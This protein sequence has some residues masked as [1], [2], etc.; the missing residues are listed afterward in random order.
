[1]RNY[2]KKRLKSYQRRNR[3]Y[4]ISFKRFNTGRRIKLGLSNR[5]TNTANFWNGVKEYNKLLYELPKHYKSIVRHFNNVRKK[6]PKNVGFYYVIKTEI[7][8]EGN[9]KKTFFSVLGSGKDLTD[10]LS[11][12]ML[13]PRI[14]NSIN[15][16]STETGYFV[17]ATLK[18]G[19]MIF[20]NLFNDVVDEN[21]NY[22]HYDYIVRNASIQRNKKLKKITLSYNLE[23][24]ILPS[25]L[26]HSEFWSTISSNYLGQIQNENIKNQIKELNLRFKKSEEE[27]HK[28]VD[29]YH[30][31]QKRNADIA[32]QAQ[33]VNLILQ[34]A[35]IAADNYSSSQQQEQYNSLIQNQKKIRTRLDKTHLDLKNKLKN[36]RRQNT[37]I[38]NIYIQNNIPIDSTPN[39]NIPESNYIY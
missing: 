8:I 32:R 21:G 3:G 29:L 37:I 12:S 39:I 34:G 38:L 35:S 5:N 16:G 10:A 33:M 36:L 9:E 14:N 11:T 2:Q 20:E 28:A 7:D 26:V 1:M 31:I 17:R 6:L 19:K 4:L 15:R 13:L 23:Q 27:F 25:S 22:L 24:E 30:T 18:N